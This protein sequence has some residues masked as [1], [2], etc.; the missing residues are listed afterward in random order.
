M[1]NSNTGWLCA[2]DWVK[3]TGNVI[4]GHVS[5]CDKGALE[6]ALKF[7]DK[8]LYLKWNP[9]KNKGWGVWEIRRHPDKKEMVY[10]THFQGIKIFEYEYV[11]NNLVNHVLDCPR[12]SMDLVGKLKSMD[13]WNDKRWA[14]NLE[15]GEAKHREKI[16]KRAHDELKYEIKQYKQEWRDF[17]RLVSEGLN[18]G[19]VLSGRWKS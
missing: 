19:R 14:A 9:K 16:E 3:P 8:Q 5:D 11:E 6:R 12:L 18:P 15:Y 4:T 13:T 1:L 2:D 17:A 10:K 7:Y